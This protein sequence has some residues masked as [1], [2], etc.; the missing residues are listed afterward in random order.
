M[1]CLRS[2][3]ILEII[4]SL[5]KF[6]ASASIMYTFMSGIRNPENTAWTAPMAAKVTVHMADDVTAPPAMAAA[7]K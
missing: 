6:P 1:N 2:D 4:S 3:V 5:Y 7:M